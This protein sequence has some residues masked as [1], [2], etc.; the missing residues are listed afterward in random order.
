MIEVCLSKPS[1]RSCT[2]MRIINIPLNFLVS[3]L[4]SE[5]LK[6]LRRSLSVETNPTSSEELTEVIRQQNKS[7]KVLELCLSIEVLSCVTDALWIL[8]NMF[9]RE[10]DDDSYCEMILMG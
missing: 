5:L 10:E 9:S 2:V 3:A 8:G 1:V 7:F 6:Y 4:M